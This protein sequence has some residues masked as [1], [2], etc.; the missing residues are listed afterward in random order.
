MSKDDA[1]SSAPSHQVI[2]FPRGQ[3]SEKDKARMAKHGIIAIEADDPSKVVAVVPGVPIL[4]GDD[5]LL[6]ALDALA[7]AP[8]YAN[9]ADRFLST[10][11]KR[12][13]AKEKK[14]G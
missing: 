14:D 10:L 6:S 2:I 8:S 7:N 9:K 12:A 5:I 13:L 11:A 4:S 1:G 3:L